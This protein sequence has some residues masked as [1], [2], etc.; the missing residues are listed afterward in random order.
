[1]CAC[2]LAGKIAW[3]DDAQTAV[4]I[5]CTLVPGSRVIYGALTGGATDVPSTPASVTFQVVDASKTTTKVDAATVSFV[6]RADPDMFNKDEAGEA[7]MATFKKNL[8]AEIAQILTPLNKVDT[9]DTN[10]NINNKTRK[11]VTVTVTNTNT[12]T[13]TKTKTAGVCPTL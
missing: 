3:V 11:T 7:I 6:V 5:S 9:N 13:K 2:V 4:D 1:V 8:K 10:K 12:K